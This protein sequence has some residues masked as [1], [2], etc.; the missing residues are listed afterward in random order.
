MTV[1]GAVNG[2]TCG[3][4]TGKA[5][6]RLLRSDNT[7]PSNTGNI[8]S[9]TENRDHPDIDLDQY[10]SKKGSTSEVRSSPRFSEGS[11]LFKTGDSSGEEDN[12]DKTDQQDLTE[13]PREN[14][15]PTQ[16]V[17][18]EVAVDEEIEMEPIPT[19]P[20]KKVEKPTVEATPVK[21]YKPKV[22]YPQ[23]LKQGKIKENFKKFVDLIQNVNITVPLVDLLAVLAC[24]E[25]EHE[26][27]EEMMHEI[28]ALNVDETP[29]EDEPFEEINNDGSI[30]VPTSV[31]SPPT[32][33]EL[34][35]LPDHFEYAYL[36]GTSLLPV[37]ISSSLMEDE[38]S[39][40]ITVLKAHKKAFAWK[41]SDIPDGMIR[42]CVADD[43]TRQILDACHHGPTGGHYG[44]SVTG[45][46]VY[47]ADFMGPF[48]PSNTNLYILVA[49]DYVS[50]WAEAKA[51][52]TNNARVVIHFLKKLFC[53]FGVPKALISDRGSHFTN[54]QLAKVLKMTTYKTPIGTTPFRLLYGKT[55]HLPIEIEHKAFWALK[56]CNM[57]LVEAGE[58]R[59]MQLNELDELR[60]YAYDNSLL[61]KERTKVWHDRRLRKKDFKAG[62]KVLLFLSKYKFKQPKLTS[63]WTGPFVIKHGYPSGY[64]ELFKSDGTSFIVNGHRLKLYHE[65][66]ESVGVVVDELPFFDMKQ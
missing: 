1:S 20:S 50:K 24:S 49:V 54:H 41:I 23:R 56:N 44:A 62:D 57:D 7:E 53:R 60:L 9:N 21:P 11:G 16:P 33:L 8:D 39:R 58:L 22:P 37:V 19:I 3:V 42:R 46:K 66:E 31:E 6:R 13:I 47:D 59:S 64:V 26:L 45:K 61:Y 18:P 32:D 63:R 30:R 14:P 35:P 48:L 51:L 25:E 10:Y 52:P 17:E 4:C 55:C 5:R 43:E 12:Q 38:K 36:E 27:V 28:M 2:F 40:L 15:Q 29:Q 65:E 34:K